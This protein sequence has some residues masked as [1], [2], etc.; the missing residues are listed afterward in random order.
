MDDREWSSNRRATVYCETEAEMKRSFDRLWGI[1][2]HHL[3]LLVQI[4]H[5]KNQ[6]KVE[7][8]HLIN[9]LMQFVSLRQIAR[10]VKRSPTFISHLKNGQSSI[11]IEVFGSL[12]EMLREEQ[13]KAKGIPKQRTD[14]R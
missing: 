3:G 9:Y 11:S 12:I 6:I 13:A 5:S 8:P 4:E 14:T 2:C 10:R 7:T 1:H